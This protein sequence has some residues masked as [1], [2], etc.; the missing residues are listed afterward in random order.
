MN[1]ELCSLLKTLDANKVTTRF[2]YQCA[3][4]LTGLK[5]SHLWQVSNEDVEE[6]LTLCH[7]NGLSNAVLCGCRRQS[8]LFVYDAEKLGAYVRK[9][10]I[11]AFLT[12]FGYDHTELGPLV[13]EMAE[14]HAAYIRGA[15]TYPHELGVLLGYPLEDVEGY[16]LHNG[17]NALYTGYWKVYGNVSEAKA[18]FERFN[19]A[20][21]QVLRCLM[22]GHSLFGLQQKPMAGL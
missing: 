22:T 20:K 14:R 7:G 4:L 16:I 11:R 5:V 12:D 8:L 2:A 9:K 19:E 17:E 18:L 15:G 3:P 6:A 1:Q 13:Q 21:A 10:E